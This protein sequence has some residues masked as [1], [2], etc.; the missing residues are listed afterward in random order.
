MESKQ[1]TNPT[2]RQ[3]AWFLALKF[4][5][6]ETERDPIGVEEDKIVTTATVECYCRVSGTWGNGANMIAADSPACPGIVP[7][8]E[9]ISTP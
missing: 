5:E 4:E 1:E 2:C 8:S 9:K 3:C 6:Y 7:L